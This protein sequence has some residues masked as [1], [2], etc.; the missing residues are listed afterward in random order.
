MRKGKN[1]EDVLI[2]VCNFTPVVYNNYRIGA[3]FNTF[4][5]E[6]LNSDAEFMAAAMWETLAVCMPLSTHFTT[7]PTL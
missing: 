1:A 3:P 2:F 5:Q 4:Y 6:I 7:G